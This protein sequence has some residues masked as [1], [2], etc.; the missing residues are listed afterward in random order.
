MIVITIMFLIAASEIKGALQ[1]SDVEVGSVVRFLHVDMT[2][3]ATTSSTGVVVAMHYNSSR[4]VKMYHIAV[5]EDPDP[6]PEG[7]PRTIDI[8]PEKFKYIMEY[9]F[10]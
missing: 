1:F 8:T 2:N 10:L 9:R 6:F 4:K 7:Y 5:A 3:A